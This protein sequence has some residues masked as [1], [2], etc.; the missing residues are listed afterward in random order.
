MPSVETVARLT[1]ALSSSN[2]R[3]PTRPGGDGDGERDAPLPPPPPPPVPPLL[4]QEGWC[5][6]GRPVPGLSAVEAT[7]LGPLPDLLEKSGEKVRG[8]R[9][10]GGSDT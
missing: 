9:G 10:A 6:R 8:I 5:A 7:D 3:S 1:D 4:L 2:P